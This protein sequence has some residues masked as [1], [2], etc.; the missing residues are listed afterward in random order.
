MNFREEIIK[1]KLDIVWIKRLGYYVASVMT[2]QLITN[3]MGV[4]K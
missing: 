2:I 4:I 1:M 3:I